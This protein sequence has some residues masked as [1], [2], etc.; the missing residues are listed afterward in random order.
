MNIKIIS[1]STCD[2]SP[3]QIAQHNITVIPLIVIKDDQEYRDGVTIT[4]ADVFAHV[5]AGGNLCSTAALNYGIYQEYFEK[6]AS[7][8]D[9]VVHI[10]L[11]SG[12]S[13]RYQNACLAADEFDNV[14][15]IDSMNLSTGQGHVVL[16]ACRLAKE[17]ESLAE[18]KEKLDAF[19][20]RVEASFLVD[21][22]NYLA[23]GGRCSA[24]AALGAN[25]L[26]L[27]PCIEVK[28]GKMS[29]VK[30][31]RGSYAK[32]LASYVKD[33]LDSREDIIRDE[34]FLT[35]TTV[36]DEC[37]A[38]V[39]GAIDQYGNFNH[40]YETQAGCTVSC[41]CGP[42]TLGILFVRK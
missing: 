23:K 24:V 5:A 12:F 30:K 16:E 13:S 35:Y 10:S 25:L 22:L 19:T 9:G 28:N 37:L 8:Y 40:V 27:K 21:K 41:H 36:T 29:V 20:P 6:Y 15:A 11:G 17:V 18:L 7:E 4:A 33:R 14:I 42:D 2:L 26:N 34:L 3:A 32:C 38:A 31:Y 39:Q 1:D